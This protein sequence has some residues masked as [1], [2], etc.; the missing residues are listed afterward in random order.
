M[1]L[2]LYNLEDAILHM[3]CIGTWMRIIHPLRS[4]S[5]GESICATSSLG[6]KTM[7]GKCKQLPGR[8]CN[9]FQQQICPQPK[10]LWG[11][12]ES[13]LPS[14]WTL[15]ESQQDGSLLYCMLRSDPPTVIRS[16]T[17]SS[18]L[19]WHACTCFG[20]SCSKIKYCHSDTSCQSF[21]WELVPTD[22]HNN[23]VSKTLSWQSRITVC[24]FIWAKVVC[25]I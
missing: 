17:V 15:Y 3:L 18:D 20:E 1:C 11:T 6:E 7:K 9:N 4:V 23:T 19:H 5:E 12:H 25:Q 24:S 13:R 10:Y 8:L 2:L 14:A 21:C 22:P 16:V